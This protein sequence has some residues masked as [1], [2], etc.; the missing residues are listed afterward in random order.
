MSETYNGWSN[1][2]T[3]RVNL[4]II[5]DYVASF[6][7]HHRFDSVSDFADHLKDYVDDVLTNF[8]ESTDSLALDYA[9]AFVSDVDWYEIAASQADD[10]DIIRAEEDDSDERDEDAAD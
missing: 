3:W 8:G 9:R 1:Y 5:D 10:S 7:R 6:D 4:E 2:A